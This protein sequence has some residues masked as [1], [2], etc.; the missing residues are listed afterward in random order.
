MQGDCEVYPEGQLPQ[1]VDLGGGAGRGDRDAPGGEAHAGGIGPK[2][3]GLGQCRQVE[4][5][6]AHAHE[7][8]VAGPLAEPGAD[9]DQ[10]FDD[11]GR[12]QVP[13]EAAHAG[14]AEDAPD[15]TAHLRGDTDRAAALLGDQHRLDPT[16]VGEGEQEL[17]GAIR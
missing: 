10:L 6:L 8:N 4:Q 7:D 9:R 3:D 2:G 5:G 12:R 11:L 16:T 13:D 17:R 15:R 1:A 14:G